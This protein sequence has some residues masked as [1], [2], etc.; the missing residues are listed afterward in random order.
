[1][2]PETSRQFPTVI[3][4]VSILS[5]LTIPHCHSR[6]PPSVIPEPPLLSFPTFVIGNPSSLSHPLTP[7][8]I[9]RKR[10]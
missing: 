6:L 5:F 2:L 7:E 4:N 3:P 9:C 8:N 1:M 10:Q